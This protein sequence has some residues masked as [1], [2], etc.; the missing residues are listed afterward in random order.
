M[1]FYILTIDK[2]KHSS[3]FS[4]QN[5]SGIPIN[6]ILFIIVDICKKILTM[7]SEDISSH[8]YKNSNSK[9]WHVPL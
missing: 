1:L 9:K 6:S 4:L 7:T 8:N 5:I 2:N 3:Q